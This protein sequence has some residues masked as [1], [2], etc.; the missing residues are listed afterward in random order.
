MNM[1]GVF[2][3]IKTL[4]LINSCYTFKTLKYFTKCI[5]RSVLETT[6]NIF[7][8]SFLVRLFIND[9]LSSEM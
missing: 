8:G 2:W 7:R 9:A 5:T 4:L 6:R 3:M 1:G